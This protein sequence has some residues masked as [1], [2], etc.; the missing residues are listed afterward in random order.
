MQIA[1]LLLFRFCPHFFF[2]VNA[3]AQ[4]AFAFVSQ[5]E[6]N[7]AEHPVDYH[8]YPDADSAHA[9]LESDYVAQKQSESEHRKQRDAHREFD[10]VRRLENIRHRERSRP[11]ENGTAVVN[12]DELERER[13]CIGRDVVHLERQRQGS[14]NY[15]VP[16]RRHKIGQL[17]QLFRVQSYLL[18]VAQTD[19]LAYDRYHR[20]PHRLTGYAADSVEVVRDRIRG[21]LNGSERGYDADDKYAP[22]VKQAALDAAGYSYREYLFISPKFGLN[23]SLI[24]I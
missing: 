14:E 17:H 12:D 8:R 24:E 19:A 3:V 2:L 9:E 22:E 13:I 10:I 1:A 6:R 21:Y 20:K 4:P 5:A 18:F 11:D 16:Y 15:C 7:R 23:L